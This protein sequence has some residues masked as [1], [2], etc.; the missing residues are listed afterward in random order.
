MLLHHITLLLVTLLLVI[1][2]VYLVRAQSKLSYWNCLH[3]IYTGHM[4]F[5]VAN[6]RHQSIVYYLVK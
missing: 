1:L 5:L 4:L 3:N 6:Q 2:Q